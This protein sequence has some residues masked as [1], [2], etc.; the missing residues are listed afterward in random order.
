MAICDGSSLPIALSVESASPHESQLA[1]STLRQKYT[2]DFPERLIG[3]KAYDSDPLD[4]C[5]RRRY[6]VELIAPNKS[7]RKKRTQDGRTLR[8][9]K[10]RWK[11]ERLFSWLQSNRRVETRFDY[12]DTC[13]LAWVQLAGIKIVLNHF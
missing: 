9:Y 1:E 11:I 8:R 4:E 13:Y 2:K 7:N 3:D 6:R 5:F 12:Y 10:R